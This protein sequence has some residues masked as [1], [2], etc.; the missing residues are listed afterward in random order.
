[1]ILHDP[2]AI[3]PP[4]KS[5]GSPGKLLLPTQ[6]TPDAW[7]YDSARRSRVLIAIAV[8]VS[9]SLHAAL[10]FG[11]RKSKAVIAAPPKEEFV[12]RLAPMPEIKDLEEPEPAPSNEA[13]Q[14]TTTLV[15][16][17]QDVPQ[18]PQPS[19]FV[20]KV[21]FDSLLERPDFSDLKISVIPQGLRSSVNLAEKIGRI[22]NLEDL[23]RAPQ[24][25][26][27]PAPAYPHAMKRE[28]IQA[29][30]LIEF[31]VDTD[32]RVL[33]PAVVETSHHSFDDAALVG[34]GRWKFRPGVRGGKKVNVRMRVPIVFKTVE[35][36]I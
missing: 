22:F 27:Q 34:V 21:N 32:G 23:D 13:P 2:V 33:A 15:P 35:A 6:V 8:V 1:M 18:L 7:R 31:V 30:V 20:Q 4:A 3:H 26:L 28:G 10:F 19:D 12:I 24:P 29:T 9:G 25:V 5:T 17:Q 14:E 11:I 36:D 16:M